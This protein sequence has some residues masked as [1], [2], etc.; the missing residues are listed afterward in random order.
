TIVTP[1][2]TQAPTTPIGLS[3]SNV[4]TSALTLNWIASAD[5]PNPGGTGVGGYNIY[6]NTNTTTPIATVTTGTSFTDSGLSS[7]TSYSYRVAAF[8]KAN[9]RNVSALSLA[10]TVTTL[11][12][13]APTWSSGDIG[14][15]GRAG[16]TTVSGGTYTVQGAGAD[17]YGTA[18]AFRFA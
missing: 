5:L 13:T 14:S 2:D 3:A 15:V 9:P 6:R 8:D 18:D 17:I 10:L 16:S 4:T 1:P 11:S 12:T 7:A